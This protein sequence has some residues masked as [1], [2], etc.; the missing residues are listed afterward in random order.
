M[1]EKD[2]KLLTGVEGL[3]RV[4]NPQVPVLGQVRLGGSD[5]WGGVCVGVFWVHALAICIGNE[6]GGAP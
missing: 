5:W 4:S 1:L 3:Q 2:F 6:G